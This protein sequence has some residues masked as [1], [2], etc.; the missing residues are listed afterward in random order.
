MDNHIASVSKSVHYHIRTLCHI[1]SS[2]TQDMATTVAS[3]LVGS[4]LDYANFVLYGTMQKNVS[5]LQK[6]ENVLTRAVFNTYQSNSDTLLQQPHW[7]P[8]EY[9]INFKNANTTQILHTTRGLHIYTPSCAYARSLRSSNRPTNL[10]TVP[11]A[12]TIS[13]LIV[14]SFSV[15]SLKISNSVPPAV[16]SYNCS[17]TF[18]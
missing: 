12:R 4:R 1:C 5:Q 18:R 16:L 8:I 15:V 3:A 2:I 6:A 7:I 11:I 14:R 10:L 17:D 9:R 13:L